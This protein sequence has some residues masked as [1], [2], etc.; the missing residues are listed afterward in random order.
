MSK[1]KKALS[2]EG[3]AKRNFYY[4]VLPAFFI[5]AIVIIVPFFLGFY[6]SLTDWKSVT[7]TNLKFVGLKNFTD[8]LSNTRFQYSL[9]ITVIFALF[10]VIVVNLVSFGLALLVAS[11]IKLKDIFRAGFFIPNLIGGL[12][13]GYIWQFIY[14]SVFPALGAAIGSQFLVDNLFLGDVKLAVLALIITN[15]WQYA[16]YIMM[17]YFAALQN[18]PSD[19]I[20]SASLDGANAWERL[21][22]ITIP[23]VMPA[24]TVSLF[25]TI[26]NSFKI[27]DVNFSLT[28]GGPSLLWHDQAIQGTEFITMNIYTT[29]SGD[30]LMAQGQAR[31]VILFFI[32]VVVSL[33][34]TSITKRKEIEV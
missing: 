10:N 25:L 14:N 11:K 24:F 8:S 7:Q 29:A 30:N 5:F 20:E 17:I 18:V 33:I 3:R 28:G 1:N 19:L 15:T 26:T 34:Q 2:R 16:G 32:L 6:Y 27:F 22:H 13:L 21:K 23:M 31:A 4:L 9:M 12:V